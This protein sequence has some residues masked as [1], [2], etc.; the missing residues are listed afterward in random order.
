MR[1]LKMRASFGKLKGELELKEGFNCLCLP[2]ESGKS[3]WS[4]F[5]CAMLYGIDTSERAS[6]ANQGLP[7]KERYKP[8]DGSAMEGAV[9]LLWQGR[10]ITI[11][12]ST[13]GR[14]PMGVFR[15]YETAS[16]IPVAE[17]NAENCG[18]TLCGVERSVFERTAFIRQLGLAVT[19]DAAL[20]KRLGA[21]VSTGEDG[22]K[23]Y[24]ELE[25]ELRN[26]RNKLLGR[27]GLLPQLREEKEETAG[28]LGRIHALREELMSL[29]A[30]KESAHKEQHTATALLERIAR[31]KE[32][33]R[34]A[35]LTAI[36]EKL[37]QQEQLCIR[38]EET[39]AQLPPRE[40]LLALQ[41]KLENSEN[42]LQTA[43]MDAA[44][45]VGQV[46]KPDVPQGFASLNA[47]GAREQAA[48]D[49]KEYYL[50]SQTQAKKHTLPLIIACLL[51]VAGAALTFVQ[52]YLGLG[53]CLAGLA[54][55]ILCLALR[56][57]NKNAVTEAHHSAQRI[58]LRYGLENCAELPQIAEKYAAELESYEKKCRDLEVQKQALAEAVLTAQAEL[59]GVLA[60]I[61]AFA[62]HADSVPSCRDALSA[63]LRTHEEVLSQQR[64]LDAMKQQHKTMVAVLG[65]RSRGQADEEALLLDEAKISY[66]ERAAAQKAERITSRLNQIQGA[67][68][69]MGDSV[70]LEAHKEQLSEEIAKAEMQAEA[71]DLALA[72]LKRADEALRSRFSPQITAEAG[73]LLAELTE[74][75][76]P[77]VLL[78]PNLS[79]SV[80][81]E[82]GAVMR[83]A[84][85]MSCGTADQMY[86][87]LRLAMCRRLLPQDAPLIL[88]DALVNFDEKRASA[89]ISLLKKEAEHRQVILF[90]CR[91][92]EEV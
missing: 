63:A 41:R 64:A 51:M 45:G 21:L 32:A 58:I 88:D 22:A 72:A 62:P 57:K 10:R 49:V 44:F 30:E 55:L 74:G 47:Q 83:P 11:E 70:A 35:G 14:I 82:G 67:I 29:T 3:T 91:K 2:N 66:E 46:Q 1:V 80:R 25:K 50:L 69:T 77:S 43:K 73:E 53:L 6:T 79:L 38:L 48:R 59:D 5:L 37:A 16:G 42:A 90:T 36:E 56:G 33:Q 15:A 12:R 24:L 52:L 19:E 71:I 4:A 27:A 9:E 65:G 23:T 84:A 18:K 39:A 61:R 75:K 34:Q 40:A 26:R 86:L 17:L 87:A 76:Y 13:S 81:E 54:A 7:A 78:S 68:S 31:A 85:A 28:A 92:F 89:A 20:E 8:W 60:Q